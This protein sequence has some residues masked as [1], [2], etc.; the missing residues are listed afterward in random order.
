MQQLRYSTLA[1]AVDGLTRDAAAYAQHLVS[2]LRCSD[3]MQPLA[4]F[5]TAMRSPDAEEM[6]AAAVAAGAIEALER[7]MRGEVG[8]KE[9]GG[10]QVLAAAALARLMAHDGGAALA[11][12]IT[13]KGAVIIG[14]ARG[15]S[16]AAALKAWRSTGQSCARVLA[17]GERAL[18]VAGVA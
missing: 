16:G 14:P 2:Q 1:A 4:D 8:C 17:E 5:L 18:F 6:A 11:R 9:E 15:C 12:C 10:S 13:D 7:I 3:P